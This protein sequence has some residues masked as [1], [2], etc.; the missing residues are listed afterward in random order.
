[1]AKRRILRLAG[2]KV[3]RRVSGRLVSALAGSQRLPAYRDDKWQGK[4][5]RY[6]TQQTT[7]V[8]VSAPLSVFNSE[9]TAIEW[10]I[11][12]ARYAR[13]FNRKPP[14]GTCFEVWRC[15]YEICEAPKW[16]KQ[17]PSVPYGTV[18]ATAVRLTKGYPEAVRIEQV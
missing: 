7:V 17:M 4:R 3:L 2:W 5:Y 10:T 8:K 13:R 15:H 16:A 14:Y 12:R 18:F 9:R 11:Q 6:S 1:M